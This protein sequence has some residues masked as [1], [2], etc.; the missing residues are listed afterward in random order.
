MRLNGGNFLPFSLLIPGHLSVH[1]RMGE[2]EVEGADEKGLRKGESLV[3]ALRLPHSCFGGFPSAHVGH[4][5]WV[6]K[7]DEC[8]EEGGG[9]GSSGNGERIREKAETRIAARGNIYSRG[10]LHASRFMPAPEK[11]ETEFVASGRER[12]KSDKKTEPRPML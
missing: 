12:I 10:W 9:G 5:E 7:E 4:A 6:F 8:G 3:E 11:S 2:E 1:R